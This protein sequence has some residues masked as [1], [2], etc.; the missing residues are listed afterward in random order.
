MPLSDV[1]KQVR[2]KRTILLSMSFCAAYISMKIGQ[3]PKERVIPRITV[4]SIL[5][6]FIKPGQIS[7]VE[8]R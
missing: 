3:I 2:R 1:K 4:G 6:R 7:I 8:P 5:Q